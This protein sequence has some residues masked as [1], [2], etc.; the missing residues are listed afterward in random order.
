[1]GHEVSRLTRLR[2]GP[3]S[4]PEDLRPG[5]ARVL[6]PALVAELLQVA[7]ADPAA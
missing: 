5:E 3:V 4:L 1:V 6:P 2:Y 7:G